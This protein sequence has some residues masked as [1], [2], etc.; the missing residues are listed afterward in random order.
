[1]NTKFKTG[2]IVTLKTFTPDVVRW[3]IVAVHVSYNVRPIEATG[4]YA[5]RRIEHD[6]PPI[7]QYTIKNVFCR[8]YYEVVQEE[9]KVPESQLDLVNPVNGLQLLRKVLKDG[10]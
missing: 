7:I 3:E 1:M 5:P 4:E 8:S 2:D 9:L 10:K 6:G